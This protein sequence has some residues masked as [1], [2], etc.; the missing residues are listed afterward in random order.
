MRGEVGEAVRVPVGGGGER[1][2]KRLS[3]SDVI[4]KECTAREQRVE[5]EKANTHIGF[6][7]SSSSV[8]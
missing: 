3:V 1:E 2:K 4:R 6:A 7:K 8:P 5:H